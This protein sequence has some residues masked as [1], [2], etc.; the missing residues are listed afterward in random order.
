MRYLLSQLLRLRPKTY[1]FGEPHTKTACPSST[2]N[3]IVTTLL[4]N[5]SAVSTQLSWLQLQW[6]RP[7]WRSLPSWKERKDLS[8]T[9]TRLRSTLKSSRWLK[10]WERTRLAPLRW[11]WT[12]KTLETRSKCSWRTIRTSSSQ[13]DQ[14]RRQQSWIMVANGSI[15]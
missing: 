6:N 3:W 12:E 15:P 2:F 13:A 14:S 1:P 7:L 10:T 9:W 11:W 4:P 8:C 5:A